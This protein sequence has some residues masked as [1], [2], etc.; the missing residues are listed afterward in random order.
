M[1][2]FVQEA[3]V[4]SPFPGMDPYL[5]HPDLWPDV[6]N[7]LI[8]ALGDELSP[9]LRPRYY[10]ALEERTYLEEPGELALIGRPD[11]TVVKRT[12]TSESIMEARRSPAVLEVELP[13][14]EPV[15]ET[16][17]EVRSVPAGEVVT[18]IEILSPSNK[19][20]GT[21]RRVYL[22]KREVILSTRTSLVEMDLLR[23]G[24]PM[25]TMGPAVVSDYRILVSRPRRRPK[26]DLIAFGV[27]DPIPSFPL[28]LRRGEEEPTVEL[29]RIL[30]AL[31]DRASY[32]LRI[33]YRTEPVPPLP[34][35]DSDWAAAL[36]RR[37]QG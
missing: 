31:Y 30:H 32:D 2:P 35:E 21:G 34:T 16:Y 37:H 17:L 29:S 27:K 3:V 7:R 11:L 15:R 23:G 25:P 8:A 22:E 26:A 5:E 18:V 20:P 36:C 4:P 28:P 9:I 1:L 33:D 19:R 24:E 6:H 10:V 12:D 14:R 13:M